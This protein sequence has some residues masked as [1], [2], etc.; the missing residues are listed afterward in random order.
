MTLELLITLLGPTLAL[1]IASACTAIILT[2][3]NTTRIGMLERR[4]E[5]DRSENSLVREQIKQLIIESE[6]RILTAI[7]NSRHG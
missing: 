7:R 4:A 1:T 3:N 5:A 2:H 6:K